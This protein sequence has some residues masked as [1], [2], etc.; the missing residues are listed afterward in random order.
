[1]Q[2][3]VRRVQGVRRVQKGEKVG[4]KVGEKGASVEKQCK[5]CEGCKGNSKLGL[6][7]PTTCDQKSSISTY[8]G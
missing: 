5:R 7:V 3:L 6:T 8:S 2:R 4:A 1:M